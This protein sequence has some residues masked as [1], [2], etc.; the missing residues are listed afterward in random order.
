MIRL[1]PA[2]TEPRPLA[3]DAVNVNFDFTGLEIEYYGELDPV[4]GARGSGTLSAQKFEGRVNQA[5]VGGLDLQTGRVTIDWGGPVAMLDV[6]ADVAGPSAAALALVDRAP[7]RIA[8]K[9]GLAPAGP[10]WQQQEPR[11]SAACL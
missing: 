9:I 1:P 6:R 4:T 3:A 7:L 2:E 11:R 8:Q 10:G 5:K